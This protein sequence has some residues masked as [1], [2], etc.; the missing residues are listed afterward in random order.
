MSIF[1]R[2]PKVTEKAPVKPALT[3]VRGRS[4][5][6]KLKEVAQSLA[7]F[8]SNDSERIPHPPNMSRYAELCKDPTL[9]IAV[10]IKTDMVV[11]DFY[12][13]MPEVDPTV[14]PVKD[15]GIN[16]NPNNVNTVNPV[17][18]VNK[19]ALVN[20][21]K[22]KIEAIIQPDMSTVP[23]DTNAKIQAKPIDNPQQVNPEHPNKKKLE[24]WKKT[25]KATK[26][27]KQI[28]RTCIKKGFCPVEILDDYNLKILPCETFYKYQTKTGDLVK[29]TQERSND[30]RPLN[31]WKTPA[32]M[33][34]IILFCFNEDIDNPYGEAD[35]ES[36]VSLLDTRTQL[37]EDIPKMIHR[38]S[39]PT[40]IVRAN[41]DVSAVKKA[42]EDKDIDEALYLGNAAKDEVEV[43]IVEPD[44][45]VRFL[46][47][48]DSVDFQIGQKLNAPLIL[49]LKNATEASAT[50][51]LDAIDRWVQSTQNELAEILEERIYTKICGSGPIPIHKWGAPKEVL[52]DITLSD[53]SSLTDKTISKKQAQDLIRKKGIELIEDEEFLNKQP[54]PNPFNP[55]SGQDPNQQDPTADGK[56]N[57][58][59]KQPFPFQ[60]KQV[61]PNIPVEQVER[62]NDLD[63]ALNIIEA[64]H[65]ENKL[66]LVD[67]CKLADRTIAVY[68]KRLHGEDWKDFHTEMFQSFI[69]LRLVPQQKREKQVFTVRVD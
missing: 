53:I 43:T 56:P 66:C 5:F 69:Q 35:P 29:Y 57:P 28:V 34:K 58:F 36:L 22:Q 64:S 10:Q 14:K 11:P 63:M 2:S 31:E 23:V 26:K 6:T 1:K 61:V 25:T 20:G 30:L 15:Q 49:L 32:E 68:M 33:D 18:T 55:F 7:S 54:A 67:A 19:V 8:S 44:P 52:D 27:L 4:L 48:I 47:Y 3:A 16:Q 21:Q 42:V 9:S 24:E 62:L 37:N 60:P 41:G 38:F 45:Q 39:A 46:P 12:F 65:K 13:E 59:Q 50:K 40:M 17:N 51:M